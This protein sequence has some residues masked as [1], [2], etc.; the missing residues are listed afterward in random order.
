M[1]GTVFFGHLGVGFGAVV[2]VAYQDGDRRAEGFPFK[3]AGED[4][5]LVGLVTWSGDFGLAGTA[6]VEFDLEVGF[7]EGDEGRAAIDD[8][9]DAT[10]MG[11]TES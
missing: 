2:L 8:D 11:F 7:G 4:F 6:A 3:G 10:S 5:A 9:A 1:G